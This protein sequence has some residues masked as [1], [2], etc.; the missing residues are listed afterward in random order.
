MATDDRPKLPRATLRDGKLYIEGK[1]EPYF[2]DRKHTI[3]LRI[4][5]LTIHRGYQPADYG[6]TGAKVLTESLHGIAKLEGGD[7]LAVIGLIDETQTIPIEFSL[8]SISDT[9][10]KFHWHVTIGFRT[11]DWEWDWDEGVWFQGYCTRQYL[12]DLLAAV[13]RGHVDNIRVGMETTMWTRDRAAVFGSR[14]RTWHIAPPSDSESTE[15]GL[16]D[17]NISSLTWD[18]RFVPAIANEAKDPTA[19]KPQVVELSGRV[20]SMLTG[21]I[22]IGVLLVIL[23]FLRH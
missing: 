17:G 1:K 14:P 11:H 9:E 10:T 20:Y 21:L 16:E 18:E 15:P 23:T 6:G 4:G 8:R 7:R 5:A 13:R 3:W 12:D 2:Q 19:A 22:V